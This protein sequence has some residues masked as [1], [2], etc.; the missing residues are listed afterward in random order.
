MRTIINDF[1]A[2]GK[3]QCRAPLPSGPSEVCT[4][5]TCPTVSGVW[6]R[7]GWVVVVQLTSDVFFSSSYGSVCV[8][9]QRGTSSASHG[10]RLCGDEHFERIVPLRQRRDRRIS[11]GNP[12]AAHRG[13][14]HR[15]GLS[16]GERFVEVVK[17]IPQERPAR[18]LVQFHLGPRRSCKT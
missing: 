2:E 18:F 11:Q 7:R 5:I 3:R 1:D 4:G 8:V 13:A 15:V 16:P 14:T 10:L 17:L 9:G 6:V 12:T